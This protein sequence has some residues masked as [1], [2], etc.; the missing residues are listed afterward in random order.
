MHGILRIVPVK[1]IFKRLYLKI[2]TAATEIGKTSF[3]LMSNIHLQIKILG[4]TVQDNFKF[5]S[6]LHEKLLKAKDHA[7]DCTES[8]NSI[9]FNLTWFGSNKV[10]FANIWI[11]VWLLRCFGCVLITL[12]S[13]WWQWY[14]IEG[15]RTKL[16]PVTTWFL[17]LKRVY[18][19][20]RSKNHSGHGV[21]FGMA[22]MI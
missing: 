9:A 14:W 18:H 19:L 15:V 17:F 4:V 7:Y 20:I 11:R 2:I 5:A 10:L 3:T 1:S 13:L 8:D 6:H 22:C 12:C 21:D 16:V